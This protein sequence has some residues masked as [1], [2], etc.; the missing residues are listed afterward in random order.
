MAIQDCNELRPYELLLRWN[1][2]TGELKG[3]AFYERKITVMDGE[4]IRNELQDPIPVDLGTP[5]LAGL[6]DQAAAASMAAVT[7]LQGELDA[8]ATEA[9]ELNSII[10]QQA[11]RIAELEAVA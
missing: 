10:A 1:E 2:L 4:L 7:R 8:K 9:G 6:I 5:A 3:A 11:A